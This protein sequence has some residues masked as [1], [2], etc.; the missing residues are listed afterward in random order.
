MPLVPPCVADELGNLYNK[1]AVLQVIDTVAW[2]G[3]C[4]GNCWV[5]HVSCSAAMLLAKQR[6]VQL[7][8]GGYKCYKHGAGA[9]RCLTAAE[10]CG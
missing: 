10:Y 8:L 3:C 6:A 7:V 2:K 4:W 5:L 1:D 9:H